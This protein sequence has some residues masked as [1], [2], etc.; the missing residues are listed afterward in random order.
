MCTNRLSAS[1]SLLRVI[2]VCPGKVFILSSPAEEIVMPGQPTYRSQVLDHPGLVAGM[3][4][5]LRAY[6]NRLVKWL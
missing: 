5:E 1:L 3:F 2:F 4:D 6:P